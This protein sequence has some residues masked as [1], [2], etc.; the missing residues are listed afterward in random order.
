MSPQLLAHLPPPPEL[1]KD[2]KGQ[3]RS[4]ET[5]DRL[6]PFLWAYRCQAQARHCT[7]ATSGN[8]RAAAAP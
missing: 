5:G 3:H 8:Y 4:G 6:V 2:R 1:G 7:D